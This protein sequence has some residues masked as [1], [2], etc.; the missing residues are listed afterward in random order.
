MKSIIGYVVFALSAILA[1]TAA[2]W[3][4]GWFEFSNTHEQFFENQWAR[5]DTSTVAPKVSLIDTDNFRFTDLEKGGFASHDFVLKNSGTS[6]LKINLIDQSENVD[7]ILP[8]ELV[9][10]PGNTFPVTVK[11]RDTNFVGEFEG[12]ALIGT[13][14]PSA[15]RKQLRFSISGTLSESGQN[16]P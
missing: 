3:G 5:I 16:L 10:L 13:N 6:D 8:D 12:F 15:E 2:G 7:V 4:F 14:D 11:L 9:I 1:G